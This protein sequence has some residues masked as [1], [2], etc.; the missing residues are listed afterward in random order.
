MN[1]SEELFAAFARD[2]GLSP[3]ELAEMLY[4]ALMNANEAQIAA[5]ARVR[6]ARRPWPIRESRAG[7]I[8]ANSHRA[9]AGQISFLGVLP[10]ST[11]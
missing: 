3:E 10:Q 8:V 2:E 1:P 11:R 9:L 4:R 7:V 5:L 6:R